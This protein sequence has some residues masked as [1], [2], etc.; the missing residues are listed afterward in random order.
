MDVR[1]LEPLRARLDV[2]VLDRDFGAERLQAF[3][4]QIDRTRADRAA[5]RQRDIGF[6]ET[7]DERPEHEDRRAHRLDQ[8]VRREIALR[9]PR[10]DVDLHA[11]VEH[12]LHAHLA[13]QLHRR[14]DV[15]QM[16]HVADRHGLVREQARRQDRQHRVL[17]AGNPDIAVE[18]LA[19]VDHDFCHA[20]FLS[21]A[22][23]QALPLPLRVSKRISSVCAAHR[24][25]L[26]S[27]RATLPRASACAAKAHGSRRP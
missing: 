9:R 7:R 26:P 4:V 16:R 19:A 22:A 1:A 21:N 6:A 11:L 23:V 14:R 27:R 8:I 2:A 3:E 12:E 20:W 24:A 25:L 5:A 17:R 18:G 10:I 13:E 15:V